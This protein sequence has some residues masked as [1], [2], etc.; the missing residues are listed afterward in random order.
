MRKIIPPFAKGGLGGV[1]QSIPV[2]NKARKCVDKLPIE[3]GKVYKLNLS[4]G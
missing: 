2:E 1:L 3:S 4:T